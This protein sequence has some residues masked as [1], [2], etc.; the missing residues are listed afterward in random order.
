V[1][2]EIQKLLPNYDAVFQDG[3]APSTQINLFSHGLKNKKVK[4]NTFPGRHSH[5]SKSLNVSGHA[6]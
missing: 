6:V 4:F 3:M 5:N 1:H 2:S